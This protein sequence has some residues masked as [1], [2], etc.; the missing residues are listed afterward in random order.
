M[1]GHR[2][3]IVLAAAL[4]VAAIFAPAISAS[5]SPK[6]TADAIVLQLRAHGEPIMQCSSCIEVWPHT[7]WTDFMDSRVY[8]QADREATACAGAGQPE[9]GGEVEV[10]SS[11]PFAVG[12]AK[13]LK[14]MIVGTN[15][16]NT[17]CDSSEV[18]GSQYRYSE[19]EYV[20]GDVLMRLTG[21]LPATAAA[22]Y[23]SQFSAIVGIKAV[24]YL[25]RPP[26]AAP[27][28]A[29]ATLAPGLSATAI[30]SDL[31]ARGLPVHPLGP[32]ETL[33]RDTEVPVDSFISA[34]AFADPRVEQGWA[35][36]D[37]QVPGPVPLGGA[38]EIW[39]SHAAA[40]E[41]AH[42]L[43]VGETLDGD[44]YGNEVDFVADGVLLRLSGGL[45]A[46]ALTSYEAP[47]AAIV[48][49]KVTEIGKHGGRPV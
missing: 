36:E 10:W 18:P 20:A 17:L 7:G 13:C 22:R 21:Y 4:V 19:Y 16:P 25:A 24:L 35:A 3:P 41:V 11:H 47:L 9:C 5:A 6:L 28:V 33:R 26:N 43:Q 31:K 15:P 45:P 44:T 40:V 12:M 49:S 32:V 30:V 46:A 27:P 23:E 37:S 38:V 1:T 29:A 34:A 2:H 39:P 42:E 14:S 48:G 8:A